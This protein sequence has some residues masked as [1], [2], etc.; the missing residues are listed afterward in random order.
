MTR[1]LIVDDNQTDRYMLQTLLRGHGYEVITA[2][3][4]TEALKSAGHYPPDMIITDIMMPVMDGFAL[5]REWK[6]DPCLQDIP[7]VFYTATYTDPKDKDFALS[8]GAD[9]FIIKPTEPEKLIEMLLTVIHQREDGRL[10]AQKETAE[11]TVFL[12]KYMPP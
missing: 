3:N 1:I 6:K 4:G 2:A 7:F 8:L 10:Q 11:E 9:H 5:C 12:K